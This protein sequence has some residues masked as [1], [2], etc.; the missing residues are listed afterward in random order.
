MCYLLFKA[1]AGCV[2]E[3]QTL[4]NESLWACNVAAICLLGLGEMQIW[5]VPVLMCVWCTVGLGWGRQQQWLAVKTTT[6][7]FIWYLFSPALPT[8]TFRQQAILSLFLGKIMNHGSCGTGGL[9]T[10]ETGIGADVKISFLVTLSLFSFSW[11]LK[12]KVLPA[13][14]NCS[15]INNL[16]FPFRDWLQKWKCLLSAH[17]AFCWLHLIAV[18]IKNTT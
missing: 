4:L 2:T 9:Y 10:Y 12:R 16:F 7:K 1:A 8:F 3:V 17:F 6:P 14:K 18:Q 13:C 11:S 15:V 5:A